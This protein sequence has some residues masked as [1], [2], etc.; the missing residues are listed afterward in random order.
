MQRID[1]THYRIAPQERVSLDVVVD[2]RPYLATFED[3][4]KASKWESV[5]KTPTSK[6]REFV[7]PTQFDASFDEA[8][9]QSGEPDHVTYTVTFRGESGPAAGTS[10]I[11]PKGGGPIL[12]T[13]V[14]QQ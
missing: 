9:P 13:F 6:H 2:Q 8:L 7:T 11:V 4:P 5:L 3:P 1:E 14:F 12:E 10:V